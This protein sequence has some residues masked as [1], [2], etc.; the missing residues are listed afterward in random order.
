MVLRSRNFPFHTTEE[1]EILSGRKTGPKPKVVNLG[2]EFFYPPNYLQENLKSVLVFTENT[3]KRD[4][5]SGSAWEYT[6]N[7]YRPE[8][9]RDDVGCGM[10]LYLTQKGAQTKDLIEVVSQYN[11]GGGNHFLNKGSFDDE[12]DYLLLHADMNPDKIVPK[13]LNEAQTQVETSTSK[14]RELLEDISNDLGI[15]AHYFKDWPHN[16]FEFKEDAVTYLKGVI[17]TKTTQGI[18]LLALNPQDGAVLYGQLS[19]VLNGYMQHGLGVKNHDFLKE[20]AS[21]DNGTHRYYVPRENS[22]VRG[23]FNSASMFI[24]KFYPSTALINTELP[25]DISIRSR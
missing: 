5:P 3:K 1:L 22:K 13:T 10:T 11:Y 9:L 6:D 18:G 17:D 20:Y 7:I 15:S 14:R 16:H 21:S 24:K 23:S 12:L 25:V 8:I 2:D 19:K 4:I